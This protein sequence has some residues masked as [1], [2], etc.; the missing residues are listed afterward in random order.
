[1]PEGEVATTT[2]QAT[3]MQESSKHMS[4]ERP[5]LDHYPQGV[6]AEIDLDA[7]A[8]VAAV[9]ED[10]FQRYRDR[11][12]FANFGKQFSYGQ[13]DQLSRQFA[14]YLT[15]CSSSARATASRS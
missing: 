7:Y 10:S 2:V 14:G 11:P 1:M 8:S 15:G 3:T 5:W 4:N 6:P 9:L 12:A 13:I